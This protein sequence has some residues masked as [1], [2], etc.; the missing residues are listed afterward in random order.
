MH[1][2]EPS[3]VFGIEIHMTCA[4]LHR[5]TDVLQN[6][7]PDFIASLEESCRQGIRVRHWFD[8]HGSARAAIAVQVFRAQVSTLW[9]M[10]FRRA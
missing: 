1:N 10:D 3:T 9:K 2:A 8:M 6:L 4:V 5:R 7:V